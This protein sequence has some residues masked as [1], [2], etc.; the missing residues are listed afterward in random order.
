MKVV[1]VAGLGDVAVGLELIVAVAVYVSDSLLI[2]AP[3]DALLLPKN[4][5]SVIL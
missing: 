3:V 4:Q 5:N 1:R 2:L